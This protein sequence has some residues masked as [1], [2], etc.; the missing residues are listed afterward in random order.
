M[1]GGVGG[2][3]RNPAPIPMPLFAHIV[4]EHGSVVEFAEFVFKILSDD[5]AQT[6]A[7]HKQACRATAKDP[8]WIAIVDTI[9][10]LGSPNDV[11]INDGNP[12]RASIT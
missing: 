7:S 10:F 3:R 9:A 4:L 8:R 5:G 2:V 6:N 1:L 11:P 12:L